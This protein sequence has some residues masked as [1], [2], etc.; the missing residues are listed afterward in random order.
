MRHFLLSFCSSTELAHVIVF[1]RPARRGTVQ[2]QPNECRASSAELD[3]RKKVNSQ[4][5]DPQQQHLA[6]CCGSLCESLQAHQRPR[7]GTASTKLMNTQKLNWPVQR[8]CRA[9]RVSAVWGHCVFIS[10][11]LFFLAPDKGHAHALGRWLQ[12]NIDWG[13]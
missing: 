1:V 13:Q 4:G 9:E 12:T 10:Y 8:P 5:Q 3:K 2:Q 7:S 11:S 6:S